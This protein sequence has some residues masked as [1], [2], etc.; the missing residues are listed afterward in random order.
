MMRFLPA[1][2][3]IRR[4]RFGSRQAAAREAAAAGGAGSGG[5]LLGTGLRFTRAPTTVASPSP[6]DAS[7]DEGPSRQTAIDCGR[8]FARS[9]R[10]ASIRCSVPAEKPASGSPVSGS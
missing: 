1:T 9:A 10:P 8:S 4:R 5:R 7:V 2:A 6:S 3:N